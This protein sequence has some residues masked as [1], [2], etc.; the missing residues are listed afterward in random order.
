MQISCACQAHCRAR[1][2]ISSPTARLARER[3]GAVN[4]FSFLQS[5]FIKAIS[6]NRTRVRTT[7]IHAVPEN[8]RNVFATGIPQI[9]TMSGGASVPSTVASL[10]RATISYSCVEFIFPAETVVHTVFNL[11]KVME[12]CSHE[13]EGKRCCPMKAYWNRSA[14]ATYHR[15]R[16]VIFVI[17]GHATGQCC[18]LISDQRLSGKVSIIIDGGGARYGLRRTGDTVSPT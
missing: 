4:V 9:L 3:T 1:A 12:I 5:R 10:M 13:I 16:G 11:L 6:G 14:I 15:R 8:R 7:L 2:C 18:C 17:A